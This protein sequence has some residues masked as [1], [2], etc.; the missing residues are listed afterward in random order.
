MPFCLSP[1]GVTGMLRNGDAFSGLVITDDISMG[2][3]AGEG[4]SS[5]ANAVQA[6]RSGCDMVMTSDTDI[7][8][9][10]SAIEAEARRDSMFDRRLEEAVVLILRAK[11]DTGIVYTA[12]QRYARSRLDRDTVASAGSFCK[13][14]FI[15]AGK[16]AALILENS[17]EH[18]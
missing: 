15:E 5:A 6:I 7:Q 10:V 2:A 8:A 4:S 11:F 18:D 9:I 3:L 1:A 17:H 16:Q 14:E 12:R 13:H